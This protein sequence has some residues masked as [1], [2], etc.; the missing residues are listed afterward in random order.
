LRQKLC[1]TL[2]T[3]ILLFHHTNLVCDKD[4]LLVQKSMP[5]FARHV[6]ELEIVVKNKSRDR[7]QEMCG[8]ATKSVREKR[9]E[10]L[11]SVRSTKNLARNRRSWS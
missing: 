1:P 4:V 7:F 10:S 6:S 8:Q 2:G 11:R 5:D 3:I 9:F